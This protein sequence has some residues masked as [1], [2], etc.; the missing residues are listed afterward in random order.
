MKKFAHEN[1]IVNIVLG[2]LI[3]AFAIVAMFVTDILSDMVDYIVAV[4]I[5]A[6]STMRFTSDF[7]RYTTQNSRFIL[8]VELALALGAAALIITGDPLARSLG[9]VLYMRGFVYFLIMQLQ[10]LKQRFDKFLLYM[11]ILT[12]G[13]YVLF[14]GN[15]FTEQ[16][17]LILFV[18]LIGYGA[19]LLYLG[20]EEKM[21]KKRK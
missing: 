14:S 13:A 18:L 5:I 16:L 8:I 17:E 6:L 2:A 3:V 15:A 21:R 19:F 10:N 4:L 20:I 9:F 11:A 7:K 1:A 12:L